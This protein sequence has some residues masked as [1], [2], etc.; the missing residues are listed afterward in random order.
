MGWEELLRVL[1]RRWTGTGT[2]IYSAALGGVGNFAIF[3]RRWLLC[4]EN[5]IERGSWGRLSLAFLGAR[6][7]N[8]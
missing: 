3:V 4:N 8:E 6:I 2:V 7:T 1:E 5:W